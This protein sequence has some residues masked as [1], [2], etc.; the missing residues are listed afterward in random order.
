MTD[1]SSFTAQTADNYTHL[2]FKACCSTQIQSQFFSNDTSE[3][4]SYIS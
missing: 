2:H 4:S 1:Y 3:I